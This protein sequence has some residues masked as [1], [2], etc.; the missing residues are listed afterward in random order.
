MKFELMVANKMG[1]LENKVI[2]NKVIA[3]V[4]DLAGEL[5]KTS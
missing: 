3:H 5:D 2:Y 4:Y 1:E